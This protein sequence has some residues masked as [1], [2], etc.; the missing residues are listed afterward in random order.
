MRSLPPAL[1]A[2][3]AVASAAALGLA[4]HVGFGSRSQLCGPFP[5]RATTA[6]RSWPHSDADR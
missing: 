3:T 5:Y 2:A 6:G 1:G 4:Y